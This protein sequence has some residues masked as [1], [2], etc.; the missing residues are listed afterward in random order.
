MLLQEDAVDI[1]NSEGICLLIFAVDE[2]S[3]LFLHLSIFSIYVL[4]TCI[5]NEWCFIRFLVLIKF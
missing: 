3:E 2:F 1:E 5:N 4:K